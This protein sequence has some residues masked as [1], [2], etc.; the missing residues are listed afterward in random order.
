MMSGADADSG[1]F[2][3]TYDHLTSTIALSRKVENDLVYDNGSCRIG[4]C[5]GCSQEDVQAKSVLKN[6]AY[7]LAEP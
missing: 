2:V 5:G 1:C 6:L 7:T 4:C 3:K